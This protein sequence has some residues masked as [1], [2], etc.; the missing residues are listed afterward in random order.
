MR[1]VQISESVFTVQGHGVH[2]A[3]LETVNALKKLS[4]VEVLVNTRA[5]ADIC[6]IHTVGFYALKHLLFSKGRRVVSAHIVPESLI[7]SLR[8]AKS[9]VWAARWYLRFFYNHADLV[10]AVSEETKELLRKMGVKRPI[11]VINNMIDISRYANSPTLRSQARRRFGW[12]EDDWVVVSNGQVQPR[13]RVD[14]FLHLARKFPK[15]RFVWV[16]GIPFKGIAADY[17]KMKKQMDTA[18]KNTFF[19][20]VVDREKVVDYVRAGDVFVMPSDQE[21]FGL[22]VV[23]AASAG[24][25]LVLRDIRDYDNTFRDDAVVCNEAS[26]EDALYRLQT[27]KVYYRKMQNKALALASRYDST[28][29][30]QQ[31]LLV[32]QEISIADESGR[33]SHNLL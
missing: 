23:E 33:K 26:F 25:P 31:L 9:W 7:G 28:K 3:F 30:V 6:H 1:V 13:K 18:P 19:S 29:L 10:I 4:N 11:K 24:L 16:G 27:D 15:T 8:W 17:E 20:G 14:T 2:T 22:A 5:N 12:K 21:T 32:Y